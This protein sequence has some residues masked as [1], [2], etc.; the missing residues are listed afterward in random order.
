MAENVV[1]EDLPHHHEAELHSSRAGNEFSQNILG[2]GSASMAKNIS[3]DESPYH[4]VNASSS[5]SDK[6]E[7]ASPKRAAQEAHPAEG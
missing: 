7:L 3:A 1:F 6:L 2:A 4:S 5:I